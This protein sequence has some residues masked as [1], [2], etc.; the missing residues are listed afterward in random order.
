MSTRRRGGPAIASSRGGYDLELGVG[1]DLLD[2]RL[3]FE[4]A[5]GYRI[6]G[7]SEGDGILLR[8]LGGLD[9]NAYGFGADRVISAAAGLRLPGIQA[10]YQV[11]VGNVLLELTG[12]V[13]LA[14][15]AYAFPS[16]S[17]TY[18]GLARGA[19]VELIARPAYFDVV[20]ER[21]NLFDSWKGRSCAFMTLHGERSAPTL[22]TGLQW[23]RTRGDAFSD[24]QSVIVVGLTLGVGMQT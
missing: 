14:S 21:T 20:Y 5:L 24:P 6:G 9:A 3:A 17:R 16:A 18:F 13:A 12:H 8:G 11:A 2:A 10:G 4:L 19:R 15:A 1:S 23:T 22:C 7:F